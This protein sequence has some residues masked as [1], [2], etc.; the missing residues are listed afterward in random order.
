[1][2]IRIAALA[3]ALVFASAAGASPRLPPP[4]VET[5]VYATR[6]DGSI[7]IGPDGRVV[8]YEPETTLKEPLAGRVRGLA[9][10]LRFEPVEI[11]GKPVIA[12][13]KM[14]LH[15][16]AE[17]LE[18]GELQVRVEHVGFPEGEEGMQRL[19]ESQG[20]Y[21]R[22]I[23]KRV[24]VRYPK[25]ALTTGGGLSGRVL[26]ALRLAPDG[27]VVEALAR[28]SALYS[29][30]GR[31]KALGGALALFE[32]SATEA[33]RRWQF[34]VRVPD[35]AYPKPEELTGLIAVE[36][37]IDGHPQ[38]RPGLWMHETRSRERSL[39]WLDPVLADRLPDL[40]DVG[41]GGHFGLAPRR[42]RLVAPDTAV[43][44]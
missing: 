22:G 23:A 43:A 24:P 36:Y 39:P 17:A 30:K 12:R 25:E 7:E 33:I 42:F 4:E 15:L 44:L 1:M 38:P 34:D 5:P 32:R 6:V 31:E 26:V 28:E 18:T 14:R 2:A 35:G 19:P 8:R 40:G 37:F 3:T 27:T 21:I 20:G 11:D 10:R 16:V 41:N 13:T 9:E 29:V